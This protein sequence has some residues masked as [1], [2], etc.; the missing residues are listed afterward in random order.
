MDASEIAKHIDALP[1][2]HRAVLVLRYHNDLSYE[3]I[4]E[5]LGEPVSI[6]RYRLRYAKRM[7]TKRMAVGHNETV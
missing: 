3:E 5:A 4:A 7:L 6:V 2:E 1:D